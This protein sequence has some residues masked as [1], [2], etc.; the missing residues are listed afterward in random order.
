MNT[1][2]FIK[3]NETFIIIHVCQ[4]TLQIKVFLNLKQTC[5]FGC[6]EQNVGMKSLH[7]FQKFKIQVKVGKVTTKV[8]TDYVSQWY[9][10]DFS[11]LGG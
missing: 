3:W 5:S 10:V 9:Y 6:K 1:N 8:T 4:Y 2:K 11:T 7:I